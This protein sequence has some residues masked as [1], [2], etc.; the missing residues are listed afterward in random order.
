[1]PIVNG[2]VAVLFGAGLLAAVLTGLLGISWILA[3]AL[4]WLAPGIKP[5]VMRRLNWEPYTPGAAPL[6]WK[7]RHEDFYTAHRFLR[8]LPHDP[9]TVVPQSSRMPQ[10]DATDHGQVALEFLSK[11]KRLR[12]QGAQATSRR[13]PNEFKA[14]RHARICAGCNRPRMVF[15]I[16]TNL[17]TQCMF[18]R[19]AVGRAV[20]AGGGR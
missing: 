2:L 12:E 7:P 6:E 4:L 3:E 19:R 1:M 9:V 15:H 10:A 14:L 16:D 17:C 18:N 11:M 13:R 8:S 5:L 20:Q